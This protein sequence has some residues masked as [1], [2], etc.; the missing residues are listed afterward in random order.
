MYNV[1]KTVLRVAALCLFAVTLSVPAQSSTFFTEDFENPDMPGWTPSVCVGDLA[2]CFA[3]HGI[4]STTLRHVSGT[5]AWQEHYDGTGAFGGFIDH[6]YTNGNEIYWRMYERLE[7]TLDP[8][9]QAKGFNLGQN[10][11]YPNYWIMHVFG[12][13]HLTIQAQ[14][15]AEACASGGVTLPVGNNQPYDAC[16]Y[17]DNIPI[18]GTN[19]IALVN[20]QWYCQEGH[21]INNT[22][23]VADGTIERWTDGQLVSRYTNRMF[24]GPLAVNT[25]GNRGTQSFDFV[26]VYLQ[27]IAGNGDKFFDDLA[28]GNT[29]IGCGA[30]PPPDVTPPAIPTG[31]AVH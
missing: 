31:L 27:A 10:G 5:R 21:I 8:L 29:R 15:P 19:G 20:G 6:N 28:V 9:Q 4:G 24:R 3:T 17:D 13:R 26:R 7:L 11:V 30:A 25:N 18:N 1:L 12:S 16:R 23:G 14:I 22:P 2:N